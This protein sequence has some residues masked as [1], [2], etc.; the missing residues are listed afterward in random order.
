[1]KWTA[2]RYNIYSEAGEG[3]GGLKDVD[4]V[5]QREE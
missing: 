2:E 1:M 3:R 5:V 4:V